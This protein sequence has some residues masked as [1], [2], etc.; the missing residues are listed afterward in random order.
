MKSRLLAIAW[1]VAA[2]SIGATAQADVIAGWD[3]SQYERPGDLAGGG[4]T[5]VA[6]NSVFD[7][8]GAG[9]DAATIGTAT[10]G[11]GG[12]LLPTA[13]TGQNGS[14]DGVGYSPR[15]P[16]TSNVSEPFLDTGKTAFDSFSILTD[17][18]Q[19]VA[20][21][22]AM[23]ADGSVVV[24]FEATMPQSADGWAFS[25]GGKMLNGGGTDGG[26]ISCSGSCTTTVD[27][28]LSTNGGGSFGAVQQVVLT[29]EDTRYQVTFPNSGTSSSNP[30]VRLAMTGSSGTGLPVIDNAAIEGVLPE[31]GALAGLLAGAL[32]LAGLRRIRR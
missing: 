27:L 14:Q 16:I 12:T 25:F 1:G 15:G 21:R 29:P 28:R 7:D 24:D 4:S 6:T 22:F 17:E 31:P 18:G 30:V 26:Q 5:P 20:N 19:A 2:I 3:F 23:V 8:N 32:L 13:G 9:S 10:I 11:G